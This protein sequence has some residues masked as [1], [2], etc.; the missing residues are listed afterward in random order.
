MAEVEQKVRSILMTK[1]THGAVTPLD[2]TEADRQE[3][4]TLGEAE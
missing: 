4:V 2:M 3:L 1:Q